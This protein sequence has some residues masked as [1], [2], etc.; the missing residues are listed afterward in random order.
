[1]AY[2]RLIVSYKHNENNK[3]VKL[4]CLPTSK[5]SFFCTF[6]D[7]C[8]ANFQHVNGSFM[9]KRTPTKTNDIDENDLLVTL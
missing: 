2:H 9:K 3:F 5:L 6:N 7:V 8:L 4:K 1:M